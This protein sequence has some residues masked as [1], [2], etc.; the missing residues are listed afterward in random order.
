MLAVIVPV[1]HVF[2]QACIMPGLGGQAAPQWYGE[3]AAPQWFIERPA[4][5]WWQQ[6]TQPW[7]SQNTGARPAKPVTCTTGTQTEAPPQEPQTAQFQEAETSLNQQLFGDQYQF[8]TEVG[9]DCAATSGGGRLLKGAGSATQ[10][11]PEKA[12]EQGEKAKTWQA[13]RSS[14]IL[15]TKGSQ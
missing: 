7:M 5:W 12:S 3:Q 1:C 15:E 4:E 9:S 14:K 13:D 2:P 10:A 8:Q 6:F 11:E